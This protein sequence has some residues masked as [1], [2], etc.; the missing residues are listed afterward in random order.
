MRSKY[1]LLAFIVSLT[2]SWAS[3]ETI[4]FKSGKTLK[5]KII[6]QT[7][8]F[9]KVDIGIDMPVTYYRDEI[10]NIENDI[11]SD[12]EASHDQ[13][14]HPPIEI[15]KPDS[16]PE[17]ISNQLLNVYE[18]KNE[19]QLKGDLQTMMSFLSLNK[20]GQL[21]KTLDGVAFNEKELMIGALKSLVPV[22][23][24]LQNYEVRNQD[25]KAILFLNGQL[26]SLES[27]SIS[28]QQ[29]QVV[30]IHENGQWK[31]EEENWTQVSQENL[32]PSSEPTE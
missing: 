31:I 22:E 21:A 14:S 29:G 20:K 19:A 11:P 17:G 1:S 28:P 23:Y 18:M 8:D 7:S 13:Q 6:E 30:F 3:A 2:V 16:P 9:I 32:N 27:G 24:K 4:Q 5:G 26:K 15:L 12:S 25:H 10:L